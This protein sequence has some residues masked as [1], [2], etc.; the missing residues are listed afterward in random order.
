LA[1]VDRRAGRQLSGTSDLLQAIDGDEVVDGVRVH[2]KAATEHRVVALLRGPSLSGAVTDTDPGSGSE[3]L[4]VLP[5]RS[6]D[7][8]VEAKRAADAVNALVTHAYEVFNDHPANIARLKAGMPAANGLI[9]RGAGS[10]A[11]V[12]NLVTHLGLKA[13]VVTGERT[14]VGL[15]RIFG[16]TIVKKDGRK[17][18][19]HTDVEGKIDAVNEALET[20]DLVFVHFKGADIAAHDRDPA[21]KRDFL[22]RID[23]ALSKIS[24]SSLVIGI[25]GDHSTS[26]TSGHH[27]GD[28]VPSLVVG[29]QVRIDTVHRFGERWSSQGALG[30][31]NATAFITC[32]LDQMGALSNYRPGQEPFFEE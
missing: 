29:P 7:G 6:I 2:L 5:A 28:P 9:T 30:H 13:A 8:S 22:T 24:L 11:P 21:A 12:R 31:L 3:H 19:L 10:L 18:V 26:S 27:T 15:G 1:I 32:V 4:G 20:H 17:D 25:T 14:A 16:F 23:R